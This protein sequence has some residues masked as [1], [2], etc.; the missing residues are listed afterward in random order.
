MEA[1]EITRLGELLNAVG[2]PKPHEHNG[3][4]TYKGPR[5]GCVE[6]TLSFEPFDGV[7]TMRYQFGEVVSTA[8]KDAEAAFQ[9]TSSR[10]R[11]FPTAAG[12]M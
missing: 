11:D 4:I 12:P 10:L 6:P 8:F 3:A 5:W 9:Y 2:W 1:S 7:I